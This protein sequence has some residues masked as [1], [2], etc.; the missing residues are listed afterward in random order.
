M[1]ALSVEPSVSTLS[2][3]AATGVG[4]AFGGI[5]HVFQKMEPL[6]T[7]P[8]PIMCTD[9]KNVSGKVFSGGNNV[10]ATYSIAR[11]AVGVAAIAFTM[12]TVGAGVVTASP[13]APGPD[14]RV[15]LVALAAG[16]KEDCDVLYNDQMNYCYGIPDEELKQMCREA[17]WNTYLL[18][19]SSN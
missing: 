3:T 4:A 17:A 12:F 16:P 11:R 9:S 7:P 8:R 15:V 18:C 6:R 5:W 2:K 10:S 1:N 19:L 13:T 14:P